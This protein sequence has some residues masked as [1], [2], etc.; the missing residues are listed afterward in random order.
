MQ[1]INVVAGITCLFHLSASYIKAATIYESG[2]LGQVGVTNADLT[3]ELASGTSINESVFAGA[4]F[5]V[6]DAVTISRIGG[7]FLGRSNGTSFFGAIVRLENEFDFPDSCDLSSPD[8]VGATTLTFPDPSAEVFGN[9][10][11]TIDRG[12]YAVVFGSGLFGTDGRGGAIRNGVDMGSPDYIGWQPQPTGWHNLSVF[13]DMFRNH[14]FVVEG[15]HAS[16]PTTAALTLIVLFAMT[17]LFRL[18]PNGRAP[19]LWRAG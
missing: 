15:T 2:T 18:R 8:V 5:E 17:L 9:I 7:H 12:W 10:S 19:R 6:T 4:R 3:N 11:L 1:L 16:E 14:R 13:G